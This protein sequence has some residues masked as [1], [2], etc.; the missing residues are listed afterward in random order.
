MMHNSKSESGFI[1]K[2]RYVITWAKP[3]TLITLDYEAAERRQPTDII[4]IGKTIQVPLYVWRTN[5]TIRE[6]EAQVTI[7]CVLALSYATLSIC[8]DTMALTLLFPLG[9]L[10]VALVCV[11]LVFDSICFAVFVAIYN[12]QP[13]TH[14]GKVDTMFV[15]RTPRDKLF[16]TRVFTGFCAIWAYGDLIAC[17][18]KLKSYSVGPFERQ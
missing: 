10:S 17:G 7:L 9:P 6:Q 12:R 3:V 8:P 15:Y 16:W 4:S 18:W 14:T 11:T 5:E 1:E 2:I 13:E